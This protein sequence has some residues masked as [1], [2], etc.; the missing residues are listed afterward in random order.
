MWKEKLT[1][2]NNQ[3]LLINATFRVKFWSSQ[4]SVEVISHFTLPL[5]APK[6]HKIIV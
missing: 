6:L 1:A 4:V 2:E 3:N 5:P